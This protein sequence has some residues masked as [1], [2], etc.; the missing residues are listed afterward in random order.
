MNYTAFQLD[1]FLLCAFQAEANAGVLDEDR[2]VVYSGGWEQLARIFREQDEILARHRGKGR[3]EEEERLRELARAEIARIAKQAEES[4]RARDLEQ[5]AR[6]VDSEALA[7]RDFYRR[8][9]EDRLAEILAR[10]ASRLEAERIAADVAAAA[11]I[12]IARLQAEEELL[13]LAIL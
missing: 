3:D 2:T 6:R 8:E 1:A 10:E 11:A 12:R 5:I 13:I 9:I 7:F 4:G